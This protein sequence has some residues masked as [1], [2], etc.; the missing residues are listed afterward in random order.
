MPNLV[1]RKFFLKTF[2]YFFIIISFFVFI[3]FTSAFFSVFVV[4]TPQV[5]I[6]LKSL[7]STTT[8]LFISI[9]P[10][11]ISEF[12][13]QTEGAGYKITRYQFCSEYDEDGNCIDDNFNLCP[14]IGILPENEE[15]TE[16]GFIENPS[17]TSQKANGEI[18]NIAD[19]SD[20]WTVKIKSPCF[21]GECPSD[22]DASKYGDPLPQSQKGKT[23]VCNLFVESVDPS[24]LVRGLINK[25]TAY[26]SP[27]NSMLIKAVLTG[28]VEEVPIT[29][30][31]NVM[32]IPGVMGSRLYEEEDLT[33]N[34]L[35][36]S[37]LDSKHSRLDLDS[38]G[39][40]L[41][42]IYT[43]DDTQNFGEN[44][45][46]IIDEIKGLNIYNSFIDSLRDWKNDGTIED[47]VFIPY[48][49]RLSLDDIVTFGATTTGKKLSYTNSQNFKDSFIL[50]KLSELQK[51]SPTGKVTIIAHS[52]GGL[53]AKA[54]IQKLKDTNNPLYNKIDKLI[55]VA[56]PQ[57]G[58]PDA[59]VS[60]LHGSDLG[61]GLIMDNERS[62][63]LAENMPTVYNLLPSKSYFK[64]VDPS[65]VVD[66]VVFF[67]N[68]VDFDKELSEY[69]VFVSDET[70]LKNYI[71]GTDGRT[72]PLYDET[73]LPN[74]GNSVLYDKAEKVHQMLDSWQPA[75]TTKVIQVAG[76]GEETL[77]GID[78]K[79]NKDMH[80]KSSIS[81]SPRMVVDGDGTV[82]TPSA[83]WM[84]TSTPN[85]ERWWV[86]LSKYNS[87]FS[88]N[89]SRIHRD[90]LEVSNLLKLINSVIHNESF[91]DIDNIVHNDL[92]KILS[93]GP[94]LHYT[95]HSPLTLGVLD[96]LGRYTGFDSVTGEVKTEIPNVTY[97]KLGSIQFISIPAGFS[98]QV[99]LKGYDTGSATLD[100]EKQVGNTV[101]ESTSFQGIPVSTT[102]TVTI[103]VPETF[104]VS[105]STLN[106]DTD[107]DGRI[108]KTLNAGVDGVTIYDIKPPEALISFSTTTKSIVFS[109]LDISPTKVIPMASGDIGT[110]IVDSQG[111]SSLFR[112]S[113]KR[114]GLNKLNLKLY[115]AIR[116]P[117][118]TSLFNTDVQYS[119]S[120]LAGSI[121]TFETVVTIRGMEMY[122]FTYKKSDGYTL[123]K[124]KLEN[125]F[126]VKRRAS[127]SIPT[128]ETGDN[129]VKINY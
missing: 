4:D 117:Q 100:I 95:L 39:K 71:L 50:K 85:V 124:E 76:W 77:A 24:I 53:V 40:S 64:T 46:G 57:I 73:D 112:Y 84:S 92:S 80:G 48:D 37:I 113:K 34:E 106:I 98:H 29:G 59:I 30:N 120:Q 65:F 9:D 20:L 3:P 102:T 41:K 2:S 78:Y 15:S 82:V 93:I 86:D 108:D 128:L 19:T 115:Y 14:Y 61:S 10:S 104:T 63:W 7:E 51:S 129:N 23:F 68:K 43:L 105:N 18:N 62:R 8:P 81:F 49:W 125:G 13:Y 6:T 96:S 5:D 111:N 79:V 12:D 97:K 87:F 28:E 101:L 121:N 107:S 45:T 67:E 22:Y 114:D 69:G 47:Y 72:K 42:N 123:I 31:S 36:L 75:S 94:R 16:L 60:L 27:Q 83:L 33:D 122:V 21:V 90:I 109:G 26:A 110:T 119:W 25:N 52:N 44:E 11:F 91:N 103:D 88:P 118:S 70:E 126:I 38:Q 99:I 32:F 89:L 55:L 58:T 54:L 66:K 56:V 74:I 127:L 1:S 35:W 17:D 116:N